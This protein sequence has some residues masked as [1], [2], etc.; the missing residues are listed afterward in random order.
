MQASDGR[1]YGSFDETV[2]VTPVNEPPAITSTS[3]SATML[4]QNENVTARLYTYR[5]TDPERSEIT[6]SVGGVDARFFA[7]NDR[8]EFSF[9]ED[10][11]PDFEEPA[12]SGGDN[13]YNVVVQASDDSITPNTD[14]LPVTVTVRAVN[15]G[16]E[17]TSGSS[18]F[19]IDE[20]QDLPTPSMRGST[21][22]GA[23]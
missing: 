21:R 10:S 12:D 18:S 19:T 14:M 2:T 4:R 3:I 7:I 13:V 9:K 16:P 20:N 15:E 1:N 11:P 17:V 22:R 5:A 8:G 6:W 23:R